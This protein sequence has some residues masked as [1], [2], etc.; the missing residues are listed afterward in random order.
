MPLNQINNQ[1]IIDIRSKS[2]EAGF[3]RLKDIL[4]LMG[5][6][7]ST[8]YL[9][10]KKGEFPEPIKIGPRISAWYRRDIYEYI[11]NLASAKSK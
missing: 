3:F 8:L 6:S 2:N 11:D 4:E 1:H 5:I 9:K 10:I 7:K